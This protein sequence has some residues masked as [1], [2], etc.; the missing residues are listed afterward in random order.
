LSFIVPEGDY[1]GIKFDF[2]VDSTLNHSDPATYAT[3]HPLSIYNGNFWT[4]NSGYIFTK[5]EG[6]ID[7]VASGSSDLSTAFFYHCGAD[8]LYRHIPELSHSIVVL[9]G[10]TDTFKV[11]VN[12]EQLFE[13]QSRV[14][15]V[16]NNPSTHTTDNFTLAELVVDNMSS[17]FSSGN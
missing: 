10:K 3:N 8:L 5:I 2:G 11:N 14:I 15:D 16:K 6:K 12:I 17:A 9:P 13:N 1:R 7:S 4:W